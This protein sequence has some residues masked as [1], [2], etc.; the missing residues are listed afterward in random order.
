MLQFKVKNNFELVN[1]FCLIY[2]SLMIIYLTIITL[3]Q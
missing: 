1:F 3:N 2:Q